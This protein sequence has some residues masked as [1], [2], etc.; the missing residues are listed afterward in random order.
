MKYLFCCIS[1]VM[2]F[3]GC[4]KQPFEQFISVHDRIWDYNSPV[5]FSVNITHPGV[6]KMQVQVRYSQEYTYSNVW[7]GL[8]EKG[9]DGKTSNMRMNIPLFDLSGR[10]FGSFAGKFYDRNYP[11]GEMETNQL[12]LN[13]PQTGAYTFSLQH[14]MRIDKLDGIA[15]IGIR[16]TEEK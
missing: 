11:D 3:S 16:L 5:S 7:I 4:G 15:E 13:I 6:Y 14:N 9:P 2:L 1:I 10:P 8:N 12:T